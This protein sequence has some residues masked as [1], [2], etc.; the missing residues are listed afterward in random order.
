[1]YYGD[2][3]SRCLWQAED[4]SGVAHVPQ[5]E[6]D[7]VAERSHKRGEVKWLQKSIMLGYLKQTVP[8]F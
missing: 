5:Y 4:G 2:Q 7:T 6:G 8:P 3:R 1:M